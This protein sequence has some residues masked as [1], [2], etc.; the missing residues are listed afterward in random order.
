MVAVFSKPVKGLG[1]EVK[2]SGLSM[3]ECLHPHAEGPKW[4]TPYM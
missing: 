3:L 4:K 1:G 2:L